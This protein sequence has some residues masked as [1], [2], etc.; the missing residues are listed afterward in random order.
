ME[1]FDP[2]DL[3]AFVAI[4]CL[5]LVEALQAGAM[6]PED[7]ARWLFHTDMLAQLESAGAC[8]G[9]LG[10]VS[11]GTTL[12]EGSETEVTEALAQLRRGAMMVLGAGAEA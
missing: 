5:G 3:R 9:C 10:L 11:L 2:T 12:T 4:Q 7:A 6:A 1:Q 8:Q